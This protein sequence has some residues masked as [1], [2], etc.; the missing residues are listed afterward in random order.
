MSRWDGLE[1]I[2]AVADAG[3]FAGAARLLGVS[4]SHISRAVAGLENRIGAPIFTR[5]TR[6]VHLTDTGR[7]LVDHSRRIVS[8]RD[9]ALSL[10]N[11]NIEPHGELR[12]TSATALGERFAAPIIRAY[13]DRY[14]GLSIHLELTNRLIDLVGEGYDLGIRTGQVTD[15]RLIATQIATRGIQLCAAPSYLEKAGL[16]MQIDD[17]AA[18]E[19]LL[20]TVATWQFREGGKLRSFAPQGRWRCNSGTA[21]ADAALAGM[22][23]CQL[24]AFYLREY[25]ESGALLPVLEEYWVEHEPIWAAY[26]ERRH[27]L[28]KVRLL[29]EA[30]ARSLGPAMRGALPPLS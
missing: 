19:C 28:P 11:G 16:P 9:E 23:I 7:V 2:V 24:P 30:L 25:L 21:L 14:P 15:R 6:L 8:E 5:T 22:G 17:L 4:T 29:I 1:E 13:A 26:P 20:G 12:I 27:L 10:V 3:N 18:H